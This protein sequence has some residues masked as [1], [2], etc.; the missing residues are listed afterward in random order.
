ML[1]AQYLLVSQTASYRSQLP[2]PVP[3]WNTPRVE[4]PPLRLLAI[5][6]LPPPL[7]EWLP[8]LTTTL[9]APSA[10][11]L[12]PPTAP[13]AAAPVTPSAKPR[14]QRAGP[15]CDSCRL[16][17]VKCTAVIVVL[18][19][20]E[21]ETL[22]TQHPS[23]AQ[24]LQAPAGEGALECPLPGTEF[25]LVKVV[26]RDCADLVIRFLPCRACSCKLLPCEFSKGYIKN[27]Y[28]PRSHLPSSKGVAKPRAR[29]LLVDLRTLALPPP[30]A[31][32]KLSCLGCRQRK[33]RCEFDSSHAECTNCQ[34]RDRSCV[35]EQ[36][37][38]RSIG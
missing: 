25:L 9:S 5:L 4:L 20:A 16:R 24:F 19:P 13:A 30:L 12:S 28:F 7:P 27:E 14:R 2:Q 17:K 29:A 3:R 23:V 26:S 8:K 33:V 22:S 37:R 15:L 32:R 31:L 36:V 38:F 10:P 11:L 34:R 21:L 1:L 6:L 35:M 18:Q